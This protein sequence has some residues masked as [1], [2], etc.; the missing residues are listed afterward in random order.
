MNAMFG[1]ANFAELL[2]NPMVQQMT[3]QMM[4]N[5]QMMENLMRNNPLF[6]GAGGA[7][8]NAGAAGAAP[9]AFGIPLGGVGNVVPLPSVDLQ[10]QM[11]YPQVMANPEVI[12]ATQQLQNAVTAFQNAVNNAPLPAAPA[13]GAGA[14]GAGAGAASSPPPAGAAAGRAPLSQSA[15]GGNP[16][17]S[18]FASA[19]AA[20]PRAQSASPAAAAAAPVQQQTPQQLAARY[21][22]ELR[23]LSDMGFSNAD[24]NLRALI[25]TGGNVNAALEMLLN[26]GGI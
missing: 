9:F 7:G 4:Q 13:G 15:G 6:G 20:A 2:Q 3:Q 19:N 5:P 11:R 26:G 25:A 16:F 17:A 22:V 1:G 10:T 12:A 14:A 21:Q 18:L 24:A 8:A 23:Q